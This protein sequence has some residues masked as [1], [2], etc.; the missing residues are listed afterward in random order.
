MVMKNKLKKYITPRLLIGLGIGAV[1]GYAYYYFI[2]CQSGTCRI[3]SSPVNS[4]L[5][6]IVMGVLLFYKKPTDTE[7]APESKTDNKPDAVE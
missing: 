3:T 7:Q 2:G 1:A 4:T 6:G 5:Y